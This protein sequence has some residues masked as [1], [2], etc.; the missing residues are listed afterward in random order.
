MVRSLLTV[1][2]LVA[3]APV[4]RSAPSDPVTR[5]V[6]EGSATCARTQSGRV[7]C[8]GG[9]LGGPDGAPASPSPAWTDVRD[10][11]VTE[12]LVCALRAGGTIECRQM[13]VEEEGAVPPLHALAGIKDVA[14]V[15]ASGDA[16]CGRTTGGEVA[17]WVTGGP[18]QVARVK[19]LRGATD[20]VMGQLSGPDWQFPEVSFGC[21]L[22][23]K[24]AVQCFEVFR[25]AALSE[26]EPRVPRDRWLARRG[27]APALVV[28][29]ATTMKGLTGASFLTLAPVPSDGEPEVC[30]VAA[31]GDA[32]L[33]LDIRARLR[34]VLT[35]SAERRA[36]GRCTITAAGATCKPVNRDPLA[37]VARPAHVTDF[38]VGHGHAC[39]LDAGAVRCWGEGRWGQLGAAPPD[40]ATNTRPVVGLDDVIQLASWGYGTLALRKS[41]RIVWW[42]E[43]DVVGPGQPQNRP[44]PVPFLGIEN[45]T[46]LVVGPLYGC[47]LRRGGKVTCWSDNIA[48]PLQGLETLIGVTRVGVTQEGVVARVGDRLV[49]VG[50]AHLGRSAATSPTPLPGAERAHDAFVF[51]YWV[52][53]LDASPGHLRCRVET[54]KWE[55]AEVVIDPKDVV[56]VVGVATLSTPPDRLD[57]RDSFWR[58]PSAR[59]L[60]RRATG[61][62]LV[63]TLD[64]V[65]GEARARSRPFAPSSRGLTASSGLV[66]AL[67]SEA[68][69]APRCVDADGQAPHETGAIHAGA[70]AYAPRPPCGLRDDG[71]VVCTGGSPI[72]LGIG[73]GWAID[74]VTITLP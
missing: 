37:T 59:L 8:W 54:R 28:G 24:S 52:C 1:T 25:E 62:V 60:V 68:T 63:V 41:G 4:A 5:L 30:V 47:A 43:G 15:A 14:Q 17:C 71:R 51:G 46:A 35:A 2:W 40:P 32:C 10:V 64:V 7:A 70:K 38:A 18:P 56:D 58:W 3:I 53:A 73:A 9:E 34:G 19:G 33:D 49:H 23:A 57:E 12:A 65:D 42:G 16:V 55:A 44:A 13:S 72:T 22:V 36:E 20:L 31:S 48:P 11:V 26:E 61:E 6:A 21:A 74:P 27:K 29:A 45:A 67:P 66:C 39:M 69:E 50:D